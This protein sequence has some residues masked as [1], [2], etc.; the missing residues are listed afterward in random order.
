M[1]WQP[2]HELLKSVEDH[3]A[4]QVSKTAMRNPQTTGKLLQGMGYDTSW[5]MVSLIIAGHQARHVSK[6]IS[7]GKVLTQGM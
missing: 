6:K 7:K 4:V 2:T 3:P 1:G 5:Y